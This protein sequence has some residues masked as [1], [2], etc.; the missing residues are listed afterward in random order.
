MQGTRQKTCTKWEEMVAVDWETEG[1][2]AKVQALSSRLLH[3]VAHEISVCGLLLF[4]FSTI[5]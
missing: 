1:V 5:N 2:F 3:Q 4:I